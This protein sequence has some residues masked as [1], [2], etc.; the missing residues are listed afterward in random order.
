MTFLP[1]GPLFPGQPQPA[2]EPPSLALG[3]KDDPLAA[4]VDGRAWLSSALAEQRQMAEAVALP[5]GFILADGGLPPQ[6]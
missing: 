2:P 3:A 5:F 1:D 4:M 6:K